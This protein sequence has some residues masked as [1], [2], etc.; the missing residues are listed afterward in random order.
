MYINIG[1]IER[2]DNKRHH[3]PQRTIETAVKG[4]MYVRRIRHEKTGSKE[5]QIEERKLAVAQTEDWTD[6]YR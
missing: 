2:R 3:N 4:Y 1:H 5:D 6:R